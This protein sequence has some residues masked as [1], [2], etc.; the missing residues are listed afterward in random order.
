MLKM[1][2]PMTRIAGISRSAFS[3]HWHDEHVPL[4][5]RLVPPGIG[6]LT[7]IE[8]HAL[9][10]GTGPTAEDGFDGVDQLT[11][12]DADGLRRFATWYA[13]PDPDA[14]TVRA[15]EDHFYDR[16]TTF[17]IPT[18]EHVI[19]GRDEMY[20]GDSRKPVD[21]A[22]KVLAF[23]KRLP[24]LTHDEFCAHWHDRH[25]P[26]AAETTPDVVRAT[27]LAYV[28]NHAIF[29]PN[30]KGPRYDAVAEIFHA[31][32]DSVRRW[33]NWFQSDAGRALRADEANFLDT[34][35]RVVVVAHERIAL[36]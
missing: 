19:W 12:A 15:D 17:A 8:N 13:G 14:A 7:I 36:A 6:P 5:T 1:F 11:F 30:G 29:L 16:R 20:D 28:Q 22:V 25:A 4:A 18:T 32:F 23:L 9:S 26:I 31:D 24:S 21:G 34:T 2:A 33:T 3:A 27:T 10:L 35:D